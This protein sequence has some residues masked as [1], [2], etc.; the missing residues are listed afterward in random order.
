MGGR[1]LKYSYQTVTHR[2]SQ[3]IVAKLQRGIAKNL[4][5][6]SCSDLRLPLLLPV[7]HA[8]AAAPLGLSEDSVAKEGEVPVGVSYSTMIMFCDARLDEPCRLGTSAGCVR[9]RVRA[10]VC[11][12]CVCVCVCE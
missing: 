6:P 1:L 10:R 2:V 8:D 11:G 5:F 7:D 9:A 4:V 12:V 3:W